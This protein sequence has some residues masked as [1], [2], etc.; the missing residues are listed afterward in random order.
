MRKS[1]MELRKNSFLFM[2]PAFTLHVSVTKPSRGK[3]AVKKIIQLTSVIF[4][5]VSS[6]FAAEVSLLNVSYDPTR[7][8]YQEVNAAFAKQWKAKTGDDVKIRQSHG[9][10]GKQARSVIDGLRWRRV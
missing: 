2:T 7:E 9:C 3:Y 6:A 1:N 8:L 10:S 4:V 5:T